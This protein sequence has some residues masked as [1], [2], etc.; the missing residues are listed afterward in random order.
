MCFGHETAAPSKL[1]AL[2]NVLQGAHAVAL[3]FAVCIGGVHHGA[4][5]DRLVAVGVD[6]LLAQVVEVDLVIAVPAIGGELGGDVG[7]SGGILAFDRAELQVAG[8]VN[9]DLLVIGR[10]LA[11]GRDVVRI[12]RCLEQGVATG[13]GRGGRLALDG[14]GDIDGVRI[15]YA[16]EL[17]PIN[18][19]GADLDG[20]RGAR[21]VAAVGVHMIRTGNQRT[22]QRLLLGSR[23][24]H[25]RAGVVL[26]CDIEVAVRDVHEH[27]RANLGIQADQRV[28]RA[29]KM[30]D[31]LGGFRFAQI[32][33]LKQLLGFGSLR[34][35]GRGLPRI[36][37][38]LGLVKRRSLV[39]QALQLRL[40][41][42]GHRRFG[43]DDVVLSCLEGVSV[44]VVAQGMDSEFPV[45]GAVGA[46]GQLA[47]L[48]L[49]EAQLNA[50]GL[51]H[52]VVGGKLG[53]IGGKGVGA[54]RVIAVVGPGDALHVGA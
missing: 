49:G 14:G 46:I 38:V 48:R 51:V 29:L 53:A 19:V 7:Q 26:L 47:A 12:A 32:G 39:V 3:D 25:V 13:I 42:L 1:L 54:G 22:S 11:L 17:R 18:V 9:R 40:R 15:R 50:H 23:R 16:L 24:Y 52:P 30:R 28:K 36:L 5:H 2:P 8:L 41:C 20:E 27:V 31:L 44:V 43:A 35:D 45:A 21:D 37:G 4:V 6:H 33:L 10:R 34:L